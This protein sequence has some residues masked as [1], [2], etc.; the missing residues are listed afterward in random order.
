S[1]LVA[2]KGLD[3]GLNS[4]S[5]YEIISVPSSGKAAARVK[6]PPYGLGGMLK[7]GQNLGAVKPSKFQLPKDKT[8]RSALM[9]CVCTE[10]SNAALP[11]NLLKGFKIKCK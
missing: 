8:E 7:H 4:G 2:A 1:A 11:S 10:L 6:S 3:T 9:A 5:Y